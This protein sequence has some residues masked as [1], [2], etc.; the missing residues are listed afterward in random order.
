MAQCSAKQWDAAME[1]TIRAAAQLAKQWDAAMEPMI[2]AAAQLA[3]QWDAAMNR[4]PPYRPARRQPRKPKP[5]PPRRR[6]PKWPKFPRQPLQ[7]LGGQLGNI[8]LKEAWATWGDTI[9]ETV[10]GILDTLPGLFRRR[11]TVA[12]V[13]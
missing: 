5:P 13:S 6:F 3:K 7:W 2:R 1:P 4:P 11:V 9:V 10:K 12:G 8:A